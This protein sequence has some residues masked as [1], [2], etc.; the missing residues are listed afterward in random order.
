[1]YKMPL[2]EIDQKLMPIL[3]GVADPEIPEISIID[4]GIVKTCKQMGEKSIF[5]EITPTYT[6]CPAM[7]MIS[8]NIKSAF[9]EAGYDHIDLK[10][11]LSPTWTSDWISER[12]REK[13]K[14]YGI[15][16]P[17]EKTNDKSFINGEAKVV[18]CPRCESQNTELISLFGSTACKSL[19]KCL[20]CLEPFDYFKCH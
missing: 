16:P 10:L 20:E 11:V 2:E 13:M 12:G 6:G 15:V 14:A 8:V 4:L 1:M 19:Y 9:Q 17:I 7:D 3:M 18:P 5:I